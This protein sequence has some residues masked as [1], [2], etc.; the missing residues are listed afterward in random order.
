MVFNLGSLI[1][2]KPIGNIPYN[3]SYLEPAEL[4]EASDRFGSALSSA[5]GV[6][7][8]PVVNSNGGLEGI[9]SVDDLI[10]IFQN[11]W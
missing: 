1:N 2:K 11:R 5:K 8:T 4:P 9:I 10:D 7:R 6:R 3:Q